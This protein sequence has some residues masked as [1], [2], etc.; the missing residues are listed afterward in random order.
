MIKTSHRNPCKLYY[1]R[2]LIMQVF[3]RPQIY[4][5]EMQSVI[6]WDIKLM[7]MSGCFHD[8]SSCKMV[9]GI[10]TTCGTSFSTWRRVDFSA[11]GRV[12]K[13]RMNSWKSETGSE[14]IHAFRENHDSAGPCRYVWSCIA[15]VSLLGDNS[16]TLGLVN[17]AADVLNKNGL[18]VFFE[19]SYGEGWQV[20]AEN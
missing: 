15:C 7:L 3:I 2:L 1:R 11:L 10:I 14:D 4:R 6:L 13:M 12:E 16:S 17:A 20:R 8:L 18:I 19:A 9:G 5:L